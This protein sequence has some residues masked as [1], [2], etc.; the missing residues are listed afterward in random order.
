MINWLI[1]NSQAVPPQVVWWSTVFIVG[2][3]ILIINQIDGWR[4]RHKKGFSTQSNENMEA[5][6]RK[7]LD[8]RQY[9]SRHNTDENQLFC[10]IATDKQQRPFNIMR[11]RDNPTIIRL[12]LGLDEKDLGV[13][14]MEQQS[15]LRFRIGVEMARFGLLCHPD[16]PMFVHLD[17]ACDDLLT[18]NIF[19]NAVDRIRQAHVLMVANVQ[20]VLAMIKAQTPIVKAQ[21]SGNADS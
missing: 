16:K 9:S 14:P 20:V 18:E 15:A 19:L 11:P 6:L 1:V 8:K 10:F 5:I 2:F 12:L 21:N 3:S 17:L 4:E 13:I 7:W